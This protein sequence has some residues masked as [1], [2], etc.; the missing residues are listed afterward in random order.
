MSAVTSSTVTAGGPFFTRPEARGGRLGSGAG[1][2][3]VSA[4][5]LFRR[6]SSET[7]GSVYVCFFLTR[8]E[9]R[10]FRAGGAL[11]LDMGER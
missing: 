3:S 7:G 4:S 5:A 1:G 6:L 9:G 2:G 8:K 10:V 11:A